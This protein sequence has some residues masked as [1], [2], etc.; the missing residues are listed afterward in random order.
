MVFTELLLCVCEWPNTDSA[1]HGDPPL[2]V[3]HRPQQVVTLASVTHLFN[4]FAAH[5]PCMA[6]CYFP[7]HTN[8]ISLEA[9]INCFR[10][11]FCPDFSRTST[12]RMNP[13]FRLQRYRPLLTLSSQSLLTPRSSLFEMLA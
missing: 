11:L 8:K 9:H 4:S 5:L 12:T 6:L 10:G 1:V 13:R 3:Q 2:I 7:H